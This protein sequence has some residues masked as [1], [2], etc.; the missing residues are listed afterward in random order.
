MSA[1]RLGLTGSIGMGKSTT[2][3]MFRDLGVPVWDA[4]ETVH[5][6]YAAG[7]KGAEAIAKL[8]PPAVTVDGVDRKAL[9][10]WI[11]EDRA[12]LA[13]IEA[14]IHPLVAEDR[15]AFAA[16]AKTDLVVFDIPLLFEVG[17]DKDVDAVLVVSAPEEVQRERVLDRP[18]M[19]EEQFEIILGRQMPDADKRAKADYVIETLSIE[20]TKQAVAT[21]V[22][23]IRQEQADKDA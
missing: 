18:G 5:R 11:A 12:N 15:V 13:P 22:D 19:T 23:R 6:L 7:G 14:A 1:F 10:D 8:H 3:N 21:L 9:S 4:D 2:A 17:A 20:A 16:N